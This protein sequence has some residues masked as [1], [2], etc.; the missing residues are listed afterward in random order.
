MKISYL[1]ANAA[2]ADEKRNTTLV[3]LSLQYRPPSQCS[4]HLP[5]DRDREKV[6]ESL[7]QL[8]NL[9]TALNRVHHVSLETKVNV[10]Q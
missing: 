10:V 8:G 2:R 5:I 7:L 3:T 1:S 4:I 6:E 9:G